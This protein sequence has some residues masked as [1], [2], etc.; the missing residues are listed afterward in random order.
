MCCKKCVVVNFVMCLRKIPSI[1]LLILVLKDTA[2]TL[3]GSLRGFEA[4]KRR[5]SSKMEQLRSV[6]GP[7]KA[8]KINWMVPFIF[9][10]YYVF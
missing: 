8:S 3:L 2:V 5:G 1:M 4:M 10:F 7:T 9:T 6:S